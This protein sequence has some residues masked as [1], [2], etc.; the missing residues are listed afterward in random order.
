[1]GSLYTWIKDIGPVILS[2]PTV[3][4]VAVALF[5]RPLL[6][7]F[8]Q[9]E[10]ADKLRAKIGPVE[11]ERELKSLAERGHEAVSGLN[12]INEV[13]AESRLL[14]LEITEAMFG[15]IFTAD[16]RARMKAQIDE[17]RNLTAQR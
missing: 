6:D 2:W 9:M 4:L 12:R 3:G 16:Q 5:R 8:K 1:M 17:L 7:I 11:L 14:E 15:S 10:S 13:M